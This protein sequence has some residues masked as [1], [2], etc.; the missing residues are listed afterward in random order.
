MLV[1][2]SD[3]RRAPTRIPAGGKHSQLDGRLRPKMVHT[4]VTYVCT[5]MIH[6]CEPWLHTRLHTVYACICLDLALLPPTAT[7]RHDLDMQAPTPD[8]DAA[9]AAAAAR[10]TGLDTPFKAAGGSKKRAAPVM[11]PLRTG[12]VWATVTVVGK[13]M[14]QSPSVVCKDCGRSF[15]G[16]KD[17]R[18]HQVQGARARLVRLN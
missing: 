11:M 1:G 13:E 12:K 8:P 7:S 4:Y 17:L 5:C 10:I 15:C 6:V 9:P 2:L 16:G 18:P 14:T 3:T